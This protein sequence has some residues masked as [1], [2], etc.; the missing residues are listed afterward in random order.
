MVGL[1]DKPL[2]PVAFLFWSMSYF[3][4]GGMS[5]TN[6]EVFCDHIFLYLV[7]AAFVMWQS[8]DVSSYTNDI[9]PSIEPWY[10]ASTE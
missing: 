2:L 5:V 4:H 9:D 10:F 6:S 1:Q 3:Q 8:I 7:K